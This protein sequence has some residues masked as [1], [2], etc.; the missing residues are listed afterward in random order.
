MMGVMDHLG[1]NKQQWSQGTPSH[2]HACPTPFPSLPIEQEQG[3]HRWEVGGRGVGR[4]VK[5]KED[6]DTAGG[7]D[8]VIELQRQRQTVRTGYGDR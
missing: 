6:D 7:R 8:Q 5:H 1:A 4:E 3:E 2:T